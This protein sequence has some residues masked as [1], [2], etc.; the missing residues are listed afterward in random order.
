M[1]GISQIC[2]VNLLIVAN[3]FYIRLNHFQRANELVDLSEP[4]K[5]N[6]VSFCLNLGSRTLVRT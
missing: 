5:G 3:V 6:W 1:N 4:R 2:L